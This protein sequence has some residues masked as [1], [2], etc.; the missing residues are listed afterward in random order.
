MSTIAFAIATDK[1]PTTNAMVM[2]F[3]QSISV[4][5]RPTKPLISACLA[6]ERCTCATDVAGAR[7]DD[8]DGEPGGD[9][10]PVQEEREFGQARGRAPHESDLTREREE[11]VIDK[12]SE[13]EDCGAFS[14]CARAP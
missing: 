4:N 14:A 9:H 3:R 6:S 12:D 7:T 1:Q 5:E 8:D 13:R 11:V 2:M 10:V